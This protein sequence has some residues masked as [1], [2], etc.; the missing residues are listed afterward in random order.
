ILRVARCTVV[1]DGQVD[2]SVRTEPHGSPDMEKLGRGEGF[3]EYC[4]SLVGGVALRVVAHQP[5]V[6]IRAAGVVKVNVVIAREI[7]VKDNTGKPAV[8]GGGR[9]TGHERCSKQYPVFINPPRANSSPVGKL[10][11]LLMTSLN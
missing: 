6:Q 11:P 4:A 9:G 10:S 2:F 5:V 3:I 7:G 1:A 8:P